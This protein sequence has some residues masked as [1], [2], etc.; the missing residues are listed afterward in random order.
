MN[1]MF[2]L[3]TVSVFHTL[4]S[5]VAVASDLHVTMEPLLG[6]NYH[7]E[8]VSAVAVDPTNSQILYAGDRRGRIGKSIDGGSTWEVLSDSLGGEESGI[9]VVCQNWD[10]ET[11]DIRVDPFDR[12]VLYLRKNSFYFSS[13][14]G[15]K[16]WHR[17]GPTGELRT[18]AL[19]PS[20]PGTIYFGTVDGAYKSLDRGSTWQQVFSG[21]INSISI[22]SQDSQLLY[23][24]GGKSVLRSVDGGQTWDE[25]SAGIL[26]AGVEAVVS[27]A[28]HPED[29]QIAYV[30]VSVDRETFT[31][32][33]FRTQDGG[34]SWEA[35]GLNGHIIRT[36]AIDPHHPEIVYAGGG[37]KAHP[38]GTF[39]SDVSV[40]PTP[41]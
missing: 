8:G 23:A 18:I 17:V 28:V 21:T 5:Q 27:V 20:I 41:P 30:G 33:I 36:L 1:A 10:C 35:M 29:P 6:F 24:V 25:R 34:G 19:D 3:L 12:N 38:E 13:A 22:S 15:G 26:I 32:S 4:G 9:G 7:F 16:R 2:L 31:P 39:R 11:R 14:D 40:N 37:S